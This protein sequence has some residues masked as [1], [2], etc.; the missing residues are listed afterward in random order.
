MA[1]ACGVRPHSE[2][3]RPC[4]VQGTWSRLRPSDPPPQGHEVRA[5]CHS[6]ESSM[7]TAT[8]GP[9]MAR[10]LGQVGPCR[11]LQLALIRSLVEGA[12][13]GWPGGESPRLTL[14]EGLFS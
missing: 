3:S 7:A 4:L 12:R 10:F 11:E 6:L 1:R 5:G 8:S 2:P 14:S 9:S 13:H